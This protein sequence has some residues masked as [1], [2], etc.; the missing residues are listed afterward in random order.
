MHRRRWWRLN[1][2]EAGL[3]L[4]VVVLLAVVYWPARY[5]FDVT[6]D[7]GLYQS[8]ALRL[9]KQPP[10]F[11]REYPPLSA[12]IFVVPRLLAPGYYIASFALLAAL[13]T[14]LTVLAVDRLGGGGWWLLLLL[15]L[16]AAGVVF[17]RYDIFVTLLTV[18][19][20]AAGRRRRWILAEALLVLGFAF[21][22]Y[23]LLLLPLV[24]LWQW[25]GERRLPWRSI[26]AGAGL[27][28]LA[29]GGA[30]LLAPA[31]VVA[32]LRYHRDRP[33]EFESIGAALAWL[34]LPVTAEYSYGSVNLV[35]S[36]RALISVSTVA[37]LL[38]PLAVY[39]YFLAGRIGPAGAWALVLLLALAGGKVFSTQYILWVLP[40]VVMADAAAPEPSADGGLAWRRGLWIAICLLTSLIYPIGLRFLPPMIGPRANLTWIMLLVTTRNLC[41]LAACGLAV[42]RWSRAGAAPLDTLNQQPLV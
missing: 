22:L 27:L 28:L 2:R 25:R 19:A 3:V 4:G 9:L 41:W 10:E 17:F 37:S 6:D 31:Q 11:P 29:V 7:A 23:P 39:T 30:W 8:Y 20:F 16:G 33:L 18:L 15:A 21:K 40:F 1:R 38:L 12:L 26:L 5:V 42:R 32:M 14:A 34:S 13:A 24:V 35:S 36:S